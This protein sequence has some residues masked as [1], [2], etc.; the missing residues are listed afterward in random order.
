MHL[1]QIIIMG[2]FRKTGNYPLNLGVVDDKML[3]PSNAF[4]S[5]A[6]VFES[7]PAVYPISAFASPRSSEK[8]I[9]GHL[10]N[11]EQ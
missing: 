11:V 5:E 7:A 9:E 1:L 4:K 8:S 3:C 2:A 6:P 10:F